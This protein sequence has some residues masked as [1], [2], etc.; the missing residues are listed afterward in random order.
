MIWFR[1]SRAVCFRLRMLSSAPFIAIK[2]QM[3]AN[4]YRTH[5]SETDGV[6]YFCQRL[7]AHEN[8]SIASQILMLVNI[9]EKTKK[10][11][12]KTQK[13]SIKKCTY[14]FSKS[15]I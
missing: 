5:D 1:N 13:Y 11:K 14:L 8:C 12:K 10:K 6:L 15:T 7:L 2:I 4:A 9:C 3:K